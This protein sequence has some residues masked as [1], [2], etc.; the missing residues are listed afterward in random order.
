M[1]PMST[2]WSGDDYFEVSDLQRTMARQSLAGLDFTGA[3]TILDI[4]CGDGFI[5]RSIA[6][7]APQA[8]VAG[9]DPSPLMLATAHRASPSETPGPR[10]VRGDAVHLPFGQHF[11]AVVSFNALHWVRD[12]QRALEQIVAVLHP[13]GWALIQMVCDSPRSSIEDVMQGCTSDPRWADR[14]DGFVAPYEHVDPDRFGV[15]AAT[16]GLEL[17]SCSVTEREWDFGSRDAFAAWCSVGSTA[18]TDRLD[19]ADRSAFVDETVNVYETV[20]GRP[21]LFRFTQLRVVMTR[22]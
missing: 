7:S 17:T 5:T 6:A 18:W 8:F 13:T 1:S 19:P 15:L 20:A 12:Q 14:F 11:D 22:L 3:H 4:G 21:G 9:V 2:D 16:A 10:Y